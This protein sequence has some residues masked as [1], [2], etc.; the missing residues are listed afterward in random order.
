MIEFLGGCLVGGL[1]VYVYM[2]WKYPQGPRTYNVAINPNVTMRL[3]YLGTLD[4]RHFKLLCWWV[5]DGR[6]FRLLQLQRAKVLTRG[7]FE[8]VRNE[9][10]NRGMAYRPP[11]RT[12]VITPPGYAFFR[13]GGGRRKQ[14]NGK[15]N[16]QMVEA[17]Q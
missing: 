5:T 3:R 17:E 15:A 16:A 14:A 10:V 2:R 6:P 4:D 9:L 8:G 1:I 11:N 13:W 7:Q 12:T